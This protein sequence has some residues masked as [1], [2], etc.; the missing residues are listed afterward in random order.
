MSG[1]TNECI[2]LYLDMTQAIN[3]RTRLPDEV[4]IKAYN[5]TKN[6]WITG[7]IIG[8]SGQQ[9][10]SR[11]SRLGIINKMNYWTES[12]DAFLLSNYKLYKEAWKLDELASK[13]GRTKQFVC[14]QAKRLELTGGKN[15]VPIE[16]KNNLSIKAKTRLKEMGHPKGMLGKHHSSEVKAQMSIRSKR[17]W[18]DPTSIFNSDEFKQKQSDNMS[19][20]QASG[21]LNNNYSRVK[22]G[23]IEIANRVIFF[24]SSWEANVAAYLQ[25]KK[26]RKLIK[27]WEF[28]VDVFWFEKIKRGVRSYKPDFKITNNDG[29]QYYIEVKGWMDAK[30]KT[31]LNRMR[32]Y[33]PD[34]KIELLGSRE[35][36]EL[37]KQKFLYKY[38]GLLDSDENLPKIIICSIEGCENKNHSKG[39]C[40]KHYYTINGK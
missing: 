22:N 6:V 13:M 27:E 24:R 25:F 32:I 3:T 9:V 7:E 30:S 4:I 33:H 8:M 39:L 35:Y 40:R 19:K 37:K 14:R 21:K 1:C 12:D 34:V 28:E 5:K 36:K 10:H 16:F 17:L 29:S 31:K 18:N 26:E 11:L 20:L 38:W 23:T 2:W 15:H